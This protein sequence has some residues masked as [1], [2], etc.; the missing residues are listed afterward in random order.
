[1]FRHRSQPLPV[2]LAV[3]AAIVLSLLAVT[4]PATAGP[5]ER[6]TERPILIFP[7]LENGAVVF[8]NTTRAAF[9]ANGQAEFEVEINAWFEE[10]GEAFFAWLDAGNDPAQF[11]PPMPVGPP[12]VDGMVDV[13][14]KQVATKQGATVELIK[15]K[16]LPIELWALDSFGPGPCTDTAS[17]QLIGA[18]TA[19]IHR[20]DND[21]MGS[22]TRGNAFGDWLKA[23]LTTPA[24][25]QIRYSTRFHI[26]SRCH[27]EG[28]FAPPSCLVERITLG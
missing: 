20:N 11:E 4:A 15:A 3:S 26:N 21:V 27:A 10:N 28:E 1:M 22:G 5:P 8:V 17:E 18:G 23:D 9:C 19:T 7:D 24:G 6:I 12:E 25:D 14:I 16:N 13:Q 2:R